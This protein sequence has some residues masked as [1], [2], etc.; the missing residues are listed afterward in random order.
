[1]KTTLPRLPI[2]AS[3]L[4]SLLLCLSLN[5]QL[6]EHSDFAIFDWQSKRLA[7]KLQV[8]DDIIVIAI[9]DY[10]LSAMRNIAGSWVWPRTVHAQLVEGLTSANAKA[11]V[12]D[13]LFAEKDLYD[14]DGDAYFNQVMSENSTVFLASLQLTDLAGGAL[15]N[16]LP[17]SLG[18]VQTPKADSTARAS[19]IMPSAID[20]AYWQTGT[21]NFEPESDDVGRFYDVYRDT[22]GWQIKSLPATMIET[23]NLPLP[24][25]K[26]VLL[27]WQGNIQQ[28]YK[29]LPYAD[30]YQAVVNNDREFLANLQHKIIFIGATASG[31]FDAR[32]TPINANLPGIYML[33][34]ALDNMKNQRYLN[35]ASLY[36]RAMIGVACII[37]IS[38]CFFVFQ[39]YSVQVVVSAGSLASIA[40][41]L[42]V[43]SRYLLTQDYALFVGTP[44]LFST[45]IFLFYCLNY[46]YKEYQQ[47]QTNLL[48]FSRFLDPKV[49]DSLFIQDSLSPE[50]LNKKQM[51]TVLFSDIRGFTKLSENKDA[52]EVVELLN[53]Y[54]DQQVKVIFNQGGTLDK[55]IGDC[56]MAFWGAPLENENHAVDAI[57]AALL[58]EQAL[59]SFQQSL[60]THLQSLDIGIGIHSGEAIVG[61]IGSKLRIDYTVIGDAVNVASRVEQLTKNTT[62]ILVSQQTMQLAQHAFEFNFQGEFNIK[63]RE[64]T[65]NLYQPIAAKRIQ[66]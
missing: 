36:V 58:M 20:P 57:Q 25:T 49:V 64:A 40:L 55:F 37:I 28:P 51:V 21:I 27:K 15:V 63:G 31:L 8:D 17:K 44:L 3:V 45:F 26:R 24:I 43:I 23:F 54:F 16:S 50:K 13:I 56:I 59:F 5:F 32:A 33:A 18:I 7:P 14:P 29:T 52:Q 66:H 38:C 62:R 19:F 60:P 61:M 34:T 35:L 2:I 9:D 6:L 42:F 11:V 41:I 4:C 10:S 47:R 53:Q 39:R 12:F 1:M 30:V 22:Q 48:M 46:G 65:V